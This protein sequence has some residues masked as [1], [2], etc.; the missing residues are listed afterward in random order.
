MMVKIEF[1]PIDRPTRPMIAAGV[2]RVA[3]EAVKAAGDET[4]GA[5]I[6]VAETEIEI[7]ADRDEQ[8]GEPKRQRHDM[9]RPV[10]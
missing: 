4:V 6:G 2:L 9:A 3:A 1:A 10:E 5:A 8:A 7:A